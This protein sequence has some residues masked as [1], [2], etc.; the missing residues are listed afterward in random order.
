MADHGGCLRGFKM[1]CRVVSW[2]FLQKR[3]EQKLGLPAKNRARRFLM[4]VDLALE[5]LVNVGI[6]Q[7]KWRAIVPM[8]SF[9]HARRAERHLDVSFAES[10]LRE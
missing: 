9:W 3:R 8:H 4:E 1:A 10:G 6:V 2:D 7:K 5:S